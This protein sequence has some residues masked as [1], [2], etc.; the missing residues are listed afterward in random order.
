M[1]GKGITVCL[2]KSVIGT[3]EILEKWFVSVYHCNIDTSI[4]LT[5]I[6]T[7][8]VENYIHFFASHIQRRYGTRSNSIICILHVHFW[9]NM[10]LGGATL[11]EKNW[12]IIPIFHKTSALSASAVTLIAN[13]VQNVKKNPL[14]IYFQIN[15]IL[16]RNTISKYVEFNIIMVVFSQRKHINGY[17]AYLHQMLKLTTKTLV[18]IPR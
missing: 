8:H 16:F 17:H 7:F 5:F 15:Y 2:S 11:G 12:K 4:G 3:I 14:D 6:D 1:F 18:W 9:Y 13:Q 10:Q